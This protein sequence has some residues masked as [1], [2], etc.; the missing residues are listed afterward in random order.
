MDQQGKSCIE[1]D[2]TSFLGVTVS[3][4]WTFLEALTTIAPIFSLIWKQN[5]EELISAEDRLWS[6]AMK[7][8]SSRKSDEANLVSLVILA[9]EQNVN[10]LYIL[11]PYSLEAKQ[12][13]YIEERTQRCVSILDLDTIYIKII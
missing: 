11:M 1:F 13:E 2:Y 10:Q 8:L 9:Q 7:E 6:S 12:I 4:K 5:L 3:K